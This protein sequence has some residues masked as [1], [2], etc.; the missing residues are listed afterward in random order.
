MRI[1]Q[2]F[3]DFFQF[4][5]GFVNACNVVKGHAAMFFGQ[6]LGF[7]FAET[8]R[9]TS[10]SALH[11][12]HEIDPDT[13]QQKERQQ[14]QQ[15]RLENGCFLTARLDWHTG[16]NQQVSHASIFWLDRRIGATTF[17]KDNLFSVDHSARHTATFD[18]FDKRRIATGLTIGRTGWSTEKIEQSHHHQ[19]QDDPKDHVARVAQVEDSSKI[20]K[21]AR[22]RRTSCVTS[23][24]EISA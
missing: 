7:G 1:A 14:A 5:L 11:P 21:P 19:E 15:E 18:R 3:D 10:A 6:Q 8:H 17:G 22:Q 4:F 2:E 23:K 16:R 9:A 12:V 20:G 13:N 24:I